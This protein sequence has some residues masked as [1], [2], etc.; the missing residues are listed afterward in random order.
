[1]AEKADMVGRVVNG[2]RCIREVEPYVSPKGQVSARYEFECPRCGKLFT[3]RG[4]QIRNGRTRSCG[5]LRDYVAAERV[6]TI[7]KTHGMSN[8]ILYKRWNGICQRALSQYPSSSHGA[9]APRGIAL[10][11]EWKVFQNFKDW[12][13]AH[14]YFEGASIERLDNTKGYSPENCVWIDK[15][16]QAENRGTT[17]YLP[18]GKSLIRECKRLHLVET[19]ASRNEVY[20][21]ISETYRGGHLPFELL[22]AYREQDP[23]ELS[24]LL[25]AAEGMGIK[26]TT[27]TKRR[28]GWL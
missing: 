14:G 15:R 19:G 17:V 6:K 8:T 11:E 16:F 10:C 9:Y 26:V 24:V 21:R 1:M 4:C 22:R 20:R 12:A 2:V 27:Y 13:L 25:D 28:L 23:K 3:A 5:C 7:T 18:T